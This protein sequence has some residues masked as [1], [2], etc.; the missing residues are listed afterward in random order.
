V[1]AVAVFV[2]ICGVVAAQ[3]L[4]EGYK[5]RSKKRVGP[6][7]VFPVESDW[8]G[9]V[10]VA[11]GDDV[12]G[13]ETEPFRRLLSG[14]EVPTRALVLP[15]DVF[16]FKRFC[17]A[18]ARGVFG[19]GKEFPGQS[20][21]VAPV[22]GLDDTKNAELLLVENN[23]N[24]RLRK[25]LRRVP[26]EIRTSDD[27]IAASFALLA[28]V[29]M[30][31]THFAGCFMH[32]VKRLLNQIVMLQN[33][34]GVFSVGK[35]DDKSVVAHAA[36]LTAVGE[37]FAMT[38][39]PAYE[40]FVVAG[41][42]ALLAMRLKNGVWAASRAATKPD[43][44]ATTWAMLALKSCHYAGIKTDQTVYQKLVSWLKGQEK[45]QGYAC[46][47]E[48]PKWASPLLASAATGISLV[49]CFKK[50]SSSAVQ[51]AVKAL[52]A[53]RK[54][55][56]DDP[57]TLY[58]AT[59]LFF[60]CGGKEWADHIP[61]LLDVLRH[62]AVK[63][64]KGLPGGKVAAAAILALS[65]EIC[66]RYQR[67]HLRKETLD[68]GDDAATVFGVLWEAKREIKCRYLGIL[69]P[70]LRVLLLQERP[71]SDIADALKKLSKRFGLKKPNYAALLE[72]L[73]TKV[74]NTASKIE[75]I[76]SKST[77]GYVLV[78]PDGRAVV[79]V[80]A[81]AKIF[82]AYKKRVALS[83]ALEAFLN[84][85][86]KP[87]KPQKDFVAKALA[88]VLKYPSPREGV[89]D[90]YERGGAVDTLVTVVRRGGSVLHRFG[91][92]KPRK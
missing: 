38:Q 72:K 41:Y 64:P 1:R 91:V 28:T 52:L 55:L 50:P 70:S 30:G 60:H 83:L 21:P 49:F 89:Y 80:F 61:Y 18:V 56:A 25:L 39:D 19:R 87:A 76:F 36:A 43:T 45:E 51:H 12:A 44:F 3:Q 8:K 10:A 13:G 90:L 15:G 2:L 88:S 68:K 67:Y 92:R 14:L 34:K 85:D 37:C 77:S 74:L 20:N 59:Y 78:L 82:K 79:E 7:L 73:K 69:P 75:R 48:Q 65:L 26:K 81:T 58:F 32:E 35:E 86:T 31:N 71:A 42:R 47:P 23:I 40:K 11:T 62:D 9:G 6:L 54:A 27:L 46:L 66:Y 5:L 4:P 29:G 57:Y 63:I 16:A 17:V 53:N 33:R 84:K 24:A 22:V